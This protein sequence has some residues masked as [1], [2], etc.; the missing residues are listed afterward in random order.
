[1]NYATLVFVI[2]VQSLDQ[3]GH[4][5]DMKDNSAE[6][7][8]QCFLQEALVSSSGTG[9]NVRSLMERELYRFLLRSFDIQIGK[10][11]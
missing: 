6:I 9:R 2:L 7:L 10:V 5:G 1:M 3:L 4:R 11:G 8:F